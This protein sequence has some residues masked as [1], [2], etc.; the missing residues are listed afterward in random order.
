M[1]E[2]IP[3][4]K[5]E[6][7]TSVELASKTGVARATALNFGKYLERLGLLYRVKVTPSHIFRWQEGERSP[8]AQQFLDAIDCI[9]RYHERRSDHTP[10]AD[11]KAA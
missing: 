3:S 7:F 8:E 4:F 11:K 9:T 2:I 5:G 6:F 10:E 1:L